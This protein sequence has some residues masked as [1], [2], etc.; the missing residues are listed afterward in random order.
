MYPTGFYDTLPTDGIT[1]AFGPE[2]RQQVESARAQSCNNKSAEE[3]RKAL[4]GVLQKTEVSTHV[5]RFTPLAA[6]AFGILLGL[7]I[8]EAIYIYNHGLG[9]EMRFRPED[10]RQ[11]HSMAGAQEIALVTTPGASA[12]PATSTYQSPPTTTAT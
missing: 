3:C 9:K 6:W 10:L 2:I 4:N 12:A 1:I 11:I 5:K 7:M 8:T